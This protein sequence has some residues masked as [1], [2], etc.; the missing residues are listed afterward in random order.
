MRRI[1]RD[2]IL[3]YSKPLSRHLFLC[4]CTRQRQ[5][6]INAQF[7]TLEL[8]PAPFHAQEKEALAH[9]RGLVGLQI[10]DGKF[11]NQTTEMILLCEV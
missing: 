3:K 7:P 1:P 5:A 8:V 10:S 4:R 11:V 2:P 6:I 9:H